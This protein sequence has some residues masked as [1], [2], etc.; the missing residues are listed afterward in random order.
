MKPKK[1]KQKLPLGHKINKRQV[2]FFFFMNTKLS[3]MIGSLLFFKAVLDA[4]K[5][6]YY[7]GC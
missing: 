7:D 3:D 5:A 6:L 2:C 4:I 1:I